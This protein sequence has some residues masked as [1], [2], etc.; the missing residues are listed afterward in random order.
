[1]SKII[2]IYNK[3]DQTLSSNTNIINDLNTE[4]SRLVSQAYTQAMSSDEGYCFKFTL[5][6]TAV[7]NLY[8]LLKLDQKA[9]GDAFH[10]DWAYPDNANMYSDPYYH[11]LMLIIYYGMRKNKPILVNHALFI[12]LMKMWNG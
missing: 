8:T 7:M 1:M 6:V 2:E 11:I 5:Q 3:L 4:M 12:I 9:V 10:H